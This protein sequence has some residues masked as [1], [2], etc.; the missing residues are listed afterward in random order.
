MGTF[1]LVGCY[2]CKYDV[3]DILGV[4]RYGMIWYAIDMMMI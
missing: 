3:L 4:V 1:L 2:V